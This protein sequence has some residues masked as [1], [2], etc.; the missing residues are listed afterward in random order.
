M[1]KIIQLL[2]D[3]TPYRPSKYPISMLALCDDGTVWRQ[4]Y[5]NVDLMIS[6]WIPAPEFDQIATE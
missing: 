5:D 2:Y 3:Q 1:R 4:V 6:R